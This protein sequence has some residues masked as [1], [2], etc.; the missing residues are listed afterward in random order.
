MFERHDILLNTSGPF[1]K[2]FEAMDKIKLLIGLGYL[3]LVVLTIVQVVSFYLYNKRFHP[4]ARIVMPD[5]T[6]KLSWLF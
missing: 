4:F 1:P 2:E 6:S 5:P 3:F